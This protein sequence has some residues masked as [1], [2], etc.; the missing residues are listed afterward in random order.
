MNKEE[1]H[2]AL[3]EDISDVIAKHLPNFDNNIEADT[4]NLL[5]LFLE[6]TIYQLGE[7]K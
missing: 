1:L 6:E 4:W 5:M 3:T 7:T 2:L